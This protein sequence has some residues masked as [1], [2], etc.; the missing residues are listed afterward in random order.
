MKKQKSA[1]IQQRGREIQALACWNH[2]G[3][4]LEPQTLASASKNIIPIPIKKM[5]RNHQNEIIIAIKKKLSRQEAPDKE[6][7]ARNFL[8]AHFAKISLKDHAPDLLDR[9]SVEA[10][11]QDQFVRISLGPGQEILCRFPS[12]LNMV[13]RVYIMHNMP[14]ASITKVGGDGGRA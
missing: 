9:I 6:E 7:V 10:A 4:M 13:L 3:T 2:A 14:F 5:F 12:S 1:C 11:L 8:R